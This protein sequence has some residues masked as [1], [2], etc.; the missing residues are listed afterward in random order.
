MTRVPTVVL[1][2]GG[3]AGHVYP[4]IA[5]ADELRT[6][7]GADVIFVGT[8][9]GTEQSIVPRYGYPLELLAGLPFERKSGWGKVRSVASVAGG[10]FEARS[11]LKRIGADAVLG[12]GGYASVAPLLA[13]RSLRIRTAVHEANCELGLAN[14]YLAPRVDRLYS[15]FDIASCGLRR[16]AARVIG[17]PVRREIL[18]IRRNVFPLFAPPTVLVMTGTESSHF[19][20]T[21]VPDLIGRIVSGGLPLRVIHQT[22]DA[23]AGVVSARYRELG[24]EATVAPF[25]HQ[26]EAAYT[27][28]DFVIG[29]A[30]AS[31]VSEIAVCG[32]PALL[33]PHPTAAG[34]HQTGNARLF[35]RLGGVRWI[36]ERDWD[37]EA[38][39]GW[40]TPLLQRAETSN[41]ASREIRN[42]GAPRA[43]ERLASDVLASIGHETFAPAFEPRMKMA[44]PE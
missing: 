21:R 44:Q 41:E 14:R 32:I 13:A 26:I 17:M 31:S 11:F 35:E 16:A 30:G 36:S 43:A 9:Q 25:F 3:T 18:E 37:A 15:A 20:A 34:D 40:V 1:A 19:I 12:F 38:I 7:H 28:A 27:R 29:R 39:I 42:I 6:V 4:A 22:G 23:E 5:V 2:A 8:E 24:I 10:V 33:I